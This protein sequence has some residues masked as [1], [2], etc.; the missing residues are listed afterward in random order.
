[1]AVHTVHLCIRGCTNWWE[2]FEPFAEWQVRDPHRLGHVCALDPVERIIVE[3]LEI[4]ILG[5][6]VAEIVEGQQLIPFL[7]ERLRLLEQDVRR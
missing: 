7:G 4:Q 5:E 2:T 6:G 1:L 3:K